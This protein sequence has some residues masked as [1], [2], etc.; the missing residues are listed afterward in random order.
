[1]LFSD[2]YKTISAPA[3]AIYKEK[4]SKFLAFAYPVTNENEIREQLTA[5]RKVHFSANHHCYAWIL[6]F[7]KSAYRINDD[8]E[9]GGTAGR[10]IHGQLLSFDL[11]NILVVVVRYFGGTKLGVSGL[12][13][14]YKTATADALQ[15]ALIEERIVY[16][17][18]A[19]KF[20]YETI[21]QVMKLVKDENLTINSP[22][23]D[24]ECSLE[25]AIRRSR[26]ES[27]VERLKKINNVSPL[28]VKTV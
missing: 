9:P 24:T 11:T 4:A 21:N 6:G 10:P 14:A 18:Y 15:N 3:E 1:M 5:L 19:L 7:D 16:D 28:Y 22:V 25:V 2:T 26:S 20:P 8:G 12:I 27:L 17:Y 23:F 13:N